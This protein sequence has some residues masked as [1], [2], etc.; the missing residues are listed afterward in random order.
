[1]HT[2]REPLLRKQSSP[3]SVDSVDLSHDRLG[4]RGE[5]QGVDTG[6]GN[7]R[8]KIHKRLALGIAVVGLVGVYSVIQGY[9][10]RIGADITSDWHALTLSHV[11]N[12]PVITKASAEVAPNTSNRGTLNY[13]MAVKALNPPTMVLP[14]WVQAAIV[15]DNAALAQAQKASNGLSGRIAQVNTENQ[16][17]M[18]HVHQLQTTV[19]NDQLR[20][21]QLEGRLHA[22]AAQP[23]PAQMG[24]RRMPGGAGKTG[25]VALRATQK[26][27]VTA[28]G[29]PKPAERPAKGWVV[30]AVHGDKAVLQT[31][32][33]QVA[34]V[35]QGQTI[36]G[37]TVESINDTTQ[38]VT[39]SGGLAAHL[40]G[41]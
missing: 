2:L 4:V 13:E 20:M 39:L 14:Q 30:V 27:G 26:P 31:P 24:A 25:L 33:G 17:L 34:M 1:M 22:L 29:H 9:G 11:S 19:M 18:V 6:G 10:N 12:M 32:G 8:G 23:R 16:Q 21:S 38:T 3:A 5:Q 15:K 36:G 7:R 37:K 40:F 35:Q 41:K 28:R